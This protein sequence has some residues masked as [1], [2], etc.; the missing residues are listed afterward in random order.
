MNSASSCVVCVCRTNRVQSAPFVSH[1]RRQAYTAVL[2]HTKGAGMLAFCGIFCLHLVRFHC[3]SA[4]STASTSRRIHGNM[5]IMDSVIPRYMGCDDEYSACDAPAWYEKYRTHHENVC[6]L[7]C[8]RV[9][10]YGADCN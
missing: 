10:S 8:G 4:A 7:M 9:T 2:V 3:W 1:V 6:V 5:L